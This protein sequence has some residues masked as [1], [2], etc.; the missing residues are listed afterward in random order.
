MVT[1]FVWTWLMT[2]PV[3]AQGPPSSDIFLLD[4]DPDSLN[5]TGAVK[6]TAGNHYQNQP[7]FLPGGDVLYTVI[8]EDGQADIYRYQPS[9]ATRTRL[10]YTQESEYSP[11]PMQDGSSYSAVRVE[12]DGTQRLWAFPLAGGPPRLLL[13]PV[14]PVGYHLWLD[15]GDLA[16][17]VL[18]EPHSLFQVTMPSGESK[19]ILGSIGRCLK[20]IPGQNDYTVVIKP[21]EGPWA[22]H[23]IDPASGSSKLLVS[24]RGQGED[25]AWLNGETLIMGDGSSLYQFR[26]GVNDDWSQFAD[27]AE[28]GIKTI[29]R[30]AVRHDGR[31]LALVSGN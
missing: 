22:I 14:K 24:T 26:P 19:R 9:S 11:T 20:K 13:P 4:L 27:L 15:S 23:R 6:I 10:T 30:I 8:A 31:Q 2:S 28:Y 1:L 21:K 3:A 7:H 5:V 12:H 25:Y 29:T 16:L 18:G 17:F